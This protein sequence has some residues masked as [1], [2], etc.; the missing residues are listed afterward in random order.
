M[1]IAFVANWVQKLGNSEAEYE[2]AFAFRCVTQPPGCRHPTYCRMAIA[3]GATDSW[4]SGSWAGMLVEEAIQGKWSPNH[5]LNTH[6]GWLR[7][8]WQRDAVPNDS[9][10]SEWKAYGGAHAALL[11]VSIRLPSKGAELGNWYAWA[12]G[13]CC[14]F[15]LRAGQIVKSF[16]YT[17][18][19]EFTNNPKLIGT[20]SPV[21]EVRSV[22]K[23]SKGEWQLGDE[24]LLA[25]DA[26]ALWCLE[27]V[28][29][30]RCF[31]EATF[32]KATRPPSRRAF[33]D[34]VT[35]ARECGH[36]RND[37]TTLVSLR[38]E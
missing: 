27:R 5:I 17:R 8:R 33:I 15:Q 16:P 20:A 32:A 2:D 10:V 23:G 6:F 7:K 29:E 22:I 37:D 21:D 31:D 3:D 38:T 34:W 11:S 19:E 14:L 36:L 26:M 25:T 12:I 24:F 4:C 9:W 18:P 28:D 13:D 30:N 35:D 1:S